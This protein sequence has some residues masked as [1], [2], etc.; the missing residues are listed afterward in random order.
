VL[1]INDKIILS[2]LFKKEVNNKHKKVDPQ[3]EHDWYSLTVGWAIG[4]GIKPD[5]AHEFADYIRYSTDLG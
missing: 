1:T 3:D 5:K 2:E 4:K